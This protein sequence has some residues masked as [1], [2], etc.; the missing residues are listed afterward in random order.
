MSVKKILLIMHQ[1]SSDPGRVGEM[2]RTLG[3]ELDMRIPAIGDPLPSDL[4]KHHGVVIFGGPMS[5]NDDHEHFILEETKFTEKLLQSNTPYLGICLGAQIMAR[6]LGA[7]VKLHP[8]GLMEIGYYKVEPTEKGSDYFDKHLNVYQ[9]HKEGFE[10][11]DQCEL[12]ATGEYFTNQ[13]FRFG[14]NAYGIQFHPEV[15]E[16]MNRR[17]LSK[18]S[19]MLEEPGAKSAE[20]QL[21]DRARHDRELNDWAWRFLSHWTSLPEK[22]HA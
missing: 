11:P 6:V 2:L 4:S 17:W 16:A 5:A 10:L 14:K 1:A 3:F 22:S 15:T 19:H 9:W 7:N 13:A 20:E 12:L 8:E 21:K 18:A